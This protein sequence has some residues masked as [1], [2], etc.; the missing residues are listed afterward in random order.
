MILYID[1]NDITEACRQGMLRA[2]E[3]ARVSRTVDIRMRRDGK[4]HSYEADWVKYLRLEDPKAEKVP[5]G[6]VGGPLRTSTAVV[7]RP[8]ATLVKVP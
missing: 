5:R 4:Y 3:H 8:K 6:P 7:A 1:D 2:I